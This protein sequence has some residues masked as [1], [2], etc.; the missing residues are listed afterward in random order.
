MPTR[1]RRLLVA[2]WSVTMVVSAAAWLSFA[3]RSG[4]LTWG[5]V[6]N[7]GLAHALYGA[8]P[9]CIMLALLVTAWKVPAAIAF[10]AVGGFRRTVRAAATNLRR[11]CAQPRFVVYAR[12]A[13][14]ASAALIAVATLSIWASAHNGS[15]AF[16]RGAVSAI[17]VAGLLIF[18]GVAWDRL[19]AWP[20]TVALIAVAELVWTRVGERPWPSIGVA[21]ASAAAAFGLG[22]FVQTEVT[23]ALR[24]DHRGLR[25]AI[26]AAVAVALPVAVAPVALHWD[27][28]GWMDSHS[29]DVAAINIATGKAPWAQSF[30]MPF[31]QYGLAAIYW[32]VGHFFFVQ[33]LVNVALLLAAVAA[34]GYTAW[35]LFGT[36][37][38]AAFAGVLVAASVELYQ[39]THLTQIENWYVPIVCVLLLAWAH[40]WRAPRR[41]PLLMLALALA[42]AANTRNQGAIFF[43]VMCLTP[44]AVG[45]LTRRARLAHAGVCVALVAVSLVPWAYRNYVVEGRFSPAASRSSL[46]V[47]VLNDHR[48]GLYGIRY[49]EGWDTVVKDYESRYPDPAQRERA[50]VVAA[51]KAWIADPAWTV[52]AI[53]YR[54]LAYYGFLPSAMVNLGP[55]VPTDWGT[56]W[57][58]YLYWRLTPFVV[59]GLSL[60][61]L[62]TRF[63]RP[64]F[65]LL[66]AVLANLSLVLFGASPESR[67]SHPA[68]PIHALMAAGMFAPAGRAWQLPALPARRCSWRGVALLTA[69]VVIVVIAGRL[70][71][72]IDNLQRPLIEKDVRVVPGLQ[73]VEAP[74]L[75]PATALGTTVRVRCLLSNYMYP[76]KIGGTAPGMPVFAADPARETYYYAYRLSPDLSSVTDVIGVTFA[77][78]DA[79]E[80]LYEG[81]AVDL[82]GELLA[83]L[84]V[85]E[86][87]FFARQWLKIVRARQ[88]SISPADLPAYP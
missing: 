20:Q 30:Y 1:D 55:A 14:L 21:S 23:A 75:T 58:S 62:V 69:A 71:F 60:L 74:A 16:L 81:H 35:L 28:S 70:M 45:G 59:V 56:E 37:A 8:A 72:G 43:A 26:W 52:R 82:E 51:S 24:N 57:S 73:L 29:Y 47:G 80:Q 2:L 12:R 17:A 13:V 86:G 78:A 87:Q 66:L 63:N 38:S 64:Q 9:L 77:G 3:F 41:G 15:V 19:S 84:P 83:T 76:P 48:I 61:G 49:W 4:A 27:I 32:T 36:V 88:L 46:Y 33:Q 54:S 11:A 18:S 53:V 22:L 50:L 5:P 79:S 6:V 34:V 7:R 44:L 65:L 42:I 39:Y 31:Y 25:N 40:Y 67:V 68:L 10:A 85:P